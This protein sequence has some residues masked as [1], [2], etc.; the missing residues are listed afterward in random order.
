MLE[1]EFLKSGLGIHLI[2][3]RYF[4]SQMQIIIPKIVIIRSM[5]ISLISEIDDNTK[6]LP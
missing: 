5:H 6:H 2:V 1:I 3:S 4:T